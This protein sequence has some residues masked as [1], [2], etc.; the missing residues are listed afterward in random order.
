MAL[1]YL[2][3]AVR[4]M[5]RIL[6]GR[7]RSETDKDVEIAILRHEVSILR[8]QVKRP[9]FTPVDRAVLATFSQL[10]PRRLWPCFLVSPSCAGTGG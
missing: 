3:V 8:R 2:Y 7:F 9:K 6:L 5:F 10:L 4:T 1:T